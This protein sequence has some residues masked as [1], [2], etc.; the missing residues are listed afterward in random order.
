MQNSHVRTIETRGIL[1]RVRPRINLQ[2]GARPSR[3]GYS[4][5]VGKNVESELWH[6]RIR[7]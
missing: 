6:P 5:S 3:L 4:T 7:V 1:E 2:M